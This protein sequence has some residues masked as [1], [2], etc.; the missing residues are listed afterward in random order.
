MPNKRP[1]WIR[2]H[3]FVNRNADDYQRGDHEC[4]VALQ[5]AEPLGQAVECSATR[6][7]AVQAVPDGHEVDPVA[8]SSRDSRIHAARLSSSHA[9][10]DSIHAYAVSSFASDVRHGFSRLTVI[11]CFRL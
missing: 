1:A 8:A 10:A 3:K 4:D 6:C 11:R 7:N 5:G 9:A 2:L